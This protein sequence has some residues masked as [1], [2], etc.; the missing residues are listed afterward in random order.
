[1]NI[2]KGIR[3][4]LLW[5]CV[6]IF[7]GCSEVRKLERAIIRLDKNKVV[8][9]NYCDTR[10]PNKD[11]VIY[12]DSVHFDTIWQINP[13]EIDT[14][15]KNDTTVVTVTSPT[16]KVV[17]KTITKIKNTGGIYLN[18]TNATQ[19]S[20][21]RFNVTFATPEKQGDYIAV[22]RCTRLSDNSV[23]YDAGNF[24]IKQLDEAT[25]MSQLAIV[26]ALL[27]IGGVII[28]YAHRFV[29]TPQ[30]VPSYLTKRVYGGIFYSAALLM[31]T[32]LLFLLSKFV[33]TK[34]YYPVLRSLFVVSATLMG[35]VGGMGLLV[36][37]LMLIILWFS[38]LRGKK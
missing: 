23:R 1:M 36:F 25:G 24:Q 14:I 27:A 10:F 31:A 2:L 17:V 12:K 6:F 37:G 30:T 11:T 18:E 35:I 7:I 20:T 9:A 8:A 15:Y 19:Q 38:D 26:A 29:T 16:T 3:R 33:E 5:V 34:E 22:V 32:V 28:F 21:G 4:V 13:T